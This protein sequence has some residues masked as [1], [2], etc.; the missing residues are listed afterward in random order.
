MK[1]I[2]LAGG[3]GSRLWPI[4]QGVS[5][6]LLPIYDKPMV[7]YPLSQLMLAGIRNIL[8]ITTPHDQP[9]YKKILGD[10]SSF[11]VKLTYEIQLEPNG[12][13]QAFNL[14]AEFLDGDAA[15]LILGD[16][17]FYGQGLGL[18]LAEFTHEIVGAQVFAYQVDNPSDFGIVEFD[19]YG[20]AISIEEKPKVPKSKYAIPGMYFYDESVV[21]RTRK[22]SPSSRGELEITDLNLSY[23]RDGLLKVSV[24][25]R[26]TAWLDTGTPHAMNDASEFMRIIEK[27]QGLKIA[28]LEEIAYSNNWI[29]KDELIDTASKYANSDYGKYLLKIVK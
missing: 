25:P 6:Q 18:S 26:G 22:L 15:A 16:N 9:A 1:G 28:C 7:Y 10:G 8:I 4:T 20:Q 2:L 14:G 21:E 19:E 12:L 29:T 17:I 11:G 24:L 23:L 3:S 27:R 13:A 5:K